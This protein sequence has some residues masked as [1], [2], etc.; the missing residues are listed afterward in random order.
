[1]DDELLESN[2]NLQ[3][4]PKNQ[5]TYENRPILLFQTPKS[6]TSPQPKITPSPPTILPNIHSNQ[7]Y[8]YCPNNDKNLFK[9]HESVTTIAPENSTQSPDSLLSSPEKSIQ[10][11]KSPVVA[12][13]QNIT[14]TK[15]TS[16][17]NN[18]K[19]LV[20]KKGKVTPIRTK[21]DDQSATN[22]NNSSLTHTNEKQRPASIDASITQ[23]I[24]S[25]SLNQSGSSGSEIQEMRQPTR[26]SAK[27]Q[28][29]L[30]TLKV[31]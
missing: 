19:I 28:Q 29:L 17:L 1:M 5:T 27:I 21:S 25:I 7:Y 20:P 3:H 13:I 26:V 11:V 14:N 30:N 15:Q 24:S 23:K 18:S 10:L 8:D 2:H 6:P 22:I 16:H 4:T 31:Q 9:N 12:I